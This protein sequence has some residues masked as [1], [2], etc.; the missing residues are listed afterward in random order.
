M[1]I[2]KQAGAQA[3]NPL[4]LSFVERLRAGR[5]VPILSDAALVD[6]VLGGQ[7]RLVTRL[8][9]FMAY[10][11]P[12][13]DRLVQ[14]V[15]FYKLANNLKEQD[16]KSN[17][18][19]FVKN[20]IYYLAQ[21]ERVSA[22]LL[23]EAEAQVDDLAVSDFAHVLGYPHFSAG[24]DDLLPLLANLPIKVFLTTSPH[25]FVEDALTAAGKQPLTELCRWRRELDNIDPAIS[26]GYRP[27]PQQPLVYHLHG[28][29]AYPDS[30]VL[31]E[32]D[33]LE[34]LVNICQGAGN[35]AMD[36]VHGL[37][38]QA[39]FDDLIL[40]GF[41]LADWGFRGLYAG[42]IK[43]NGRQE[44]RGVCCL[45]LVPDRTEQQYLE[46]YLEREARFEVFWGTLHEYALELRR[47]L[48][49]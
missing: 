6:L 34:F 18:L 38:R 28:L 25:T 5:V 21:E 48:N 44:D 12:D 13:K 1:P 47:L 36:R 29:D 37:V 4:Q 9:E 19:N 35:N 24:A 15:R 10:P 14:V 7:P 30:L 49:L 2:I 17:Y 27:T 45:Q 8:A 20:Y 33:H 46:D 42:L 32:D 41:S 43:P 3:A 23:A 31:S 11:L 26:P 16:V 22:D 40:L 39:L